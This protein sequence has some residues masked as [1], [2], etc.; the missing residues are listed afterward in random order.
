MSILSMSGN[1]FNFCQF[2]QILKKF[3]LLLIIRV[4]RFWHVLEITILFAKIVLPNLICFSIFS[5]FFNFFQFLQNFANFLIFFQ[6]FF[7]FWQ[8]WN[9]DRCWER[10][11]YPDLSRFWHGWKCMFNFIVTFR[12]IFS[13]FQFFSFFTKSG[14]ENHG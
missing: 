5:I 10:R 12:G 8:N 13:F 7:I 6:I 4:S 11:G 14:V 1:F 2:L 9:L 3:I